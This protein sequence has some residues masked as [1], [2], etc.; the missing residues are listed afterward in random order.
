MESKMKDTR[1]E[2]GKLRTRGKS[3]EVLLWQ[4]L[5]I[6]TLGERGSLRCCYE[7]GLV[8]SPPS[9]GQFGK[10]TSS[11]KH[12]IKTRR[13]N[14]GECCYSKALSSNPKRTTTLSVDNLGLGRLFLLA[15]KW[16]G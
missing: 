11:M 1:V 15:S 16:Y 3:S 9:L 13:L 14:E 2:G 6:K 8:L 12:K 10:T 5:R 7:Q 4:G